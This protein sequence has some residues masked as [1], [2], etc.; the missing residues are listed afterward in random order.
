MTGKSPRASKFLQQEGKG[1]VLVL[2]QFMKTPSHSKLSK[3]LKSTELGE[4]DQD[5]NHCRV[6]KHDLHDL[7]LW[8]VRRRK[9]EKRKKS[10]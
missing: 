2:G 8:G 10:H 6:L 1:Y 9:G 3:G 7:R 4:I 5:S